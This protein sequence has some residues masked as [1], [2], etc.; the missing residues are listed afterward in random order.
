VCLCYATAAQTLGCVHTLLVH[1]RCMLVGLPVFIAGPVQCSL[2]ARTTCS[3][4]YM[5]Q[6]VQATRPVAVSLP[7]CFAG[8]E[9]ACLENCSFEDLKMYIGH[10]VPSKVQHQPPPVLV[11][12]PARGA[13]YCKEPNVARSEHHVVAVQCTEGQVR[14]SRS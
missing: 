8:E 4:C 2:Q 13:C 12:V 11:V 6:P 5:L 9:P 7:K 3:D 14:G 10:K 1:F